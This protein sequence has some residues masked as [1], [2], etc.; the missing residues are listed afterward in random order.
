LTEEGG[1]VM[2]GPTTLAIHLKNVTPTSLTV[3]LEPWATEYEVLPTV[4]IDVVERAGNHG[5]ALEIHV[6][7]GHITFFGR[8]GSTL[9]IV[10]DGV[11][12][13]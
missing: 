3:V 12:L 4:A 1:N 8:V 2:A 10:R 6:G 9:S 7:D 11:E 5:N 13:P